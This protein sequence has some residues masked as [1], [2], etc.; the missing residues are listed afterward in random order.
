MSTR[1][2]AAREDDHVRDRTKHRKSRQSKTVLRASHPQ[3]ANQSIQSSLEEISRLREVT[4]HLCREGSSSER[5]EELRWKINQLEKDKLE[6]TSKYN[7]EVSGYEAQLARLRALLERGEANRQTLEY[8]VAVVRRDA[9]VQKSSSEDRIADLH[10]HNQQLKTLSAE[11]SQRV[12]DLERALEITR[13]AREEDQQGLQAELHERDRLLLSSNAENDLLQAE[14]RR[15]EALLQEQNDTLKELKDKM[16]RVQKGRERD[17]EELRV[18]TSELKLSADREERMRTEVESAMQR[19]KALEE[20][21]ESERAAHLESKFNSEIIQLRL[22]DLEAAL[23]VEKNSQAEAVSNLELLRQ[24]F[25]EVEKAYTRERDR[26]KDTHHKLQQLEKEYLSTKTELIGQLDKEKAAAAELIGQLEQE[27][28][29]SVKLSLRLQEEERVQTENQHTLSLLQKKLVWVEEAHEGLLK[30]MEQL[31][32]HYHHLGAPQINNTGEGDKHSSS[33]MMDILRRTLQHYHTELKDLLKV[34]DTLKKESKEKEE[35]ITEQRRHIQECEGQCVCLGE[36]VKRLRVSVTEAAAAAD[37]AQTELRNV[38]QRWEEER[39]RHTHTRA[40]IHTLTQ[41]HERDQQEKLA[42]LHSLYQQLVAGCVLVAPPQSML[43]SFSWVELSTVLQEHVDALASDLSSAN[44]KISGLESVCEGKAAAL[45]SVCEQLKQREESWIRQREELDTHHTQLTNELQTRVQNLRRTLDQ[46][47]ESIRV[48]ERGRS[49]LEQELTRLQ[50]LLSVCRRDDASLLAAC[51][52]L[53]GCVCELYGRV[54]V[55]ARQKTLLWGRVCDGAALERE[56]GSLLHALSEPEVKGQA[57]VRGGVWA[58]RRCVIA[59]L[60]ALRLQALQRN[61]RR[62]FRVS[63]RSGESPGV[64]VREVRLREGSPRTEREEEEEERSVRVMKM[65]RSSELAVLIHSCMQ[66]VQQELDK[67]ELS[68]AVLNA[69]QNSFSKLLERLLSETDPGCWGRW[70]NV[71]ML[72]R[73]LGH[74]LQRLRTAHHI[75]ARRYTSKCMVSSLQQHFLV[76]TQRLHSAEVERRELRLELSRLKRSTAHSRNKP[77]DNTH[78][79]CVPVNQFQSVCAELSSALQ[80][81]QEVQALLHQQ[82]T[83]LQELGLTMELHT[84]DQLEKDRTLAQAVQ[85]LSEAKAELKR[86]EQSLRLLGKR[87]S[88]SQQEKQQLQQSISSAEN[89]LR[90]A[91]KNKDSL[92]SYVKSVESSLKELKDR[93]ILSRSSTS[94]EDFT[95]H[96]P[97]TLLDV[98]EPK[99][100]TGG[101]EIAACQTLVRS[102]LEVY[103]LACSKMASLEREISSYQSHITALKAELQDACLRESQI[104]V[105]VMGADEPALPLFEVEVDSGTP[106]LSDAGVTLKDIPGNLRPLQS[107]PLKKS[108]AVKKGSK[109][110]KTLKG[111]SKP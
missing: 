69:A 54:G 96:L 16:D 87:L 47:E 70:G 90:M 98:A 89:A 93:I 20:N 17:A 21:V 52:L 97:K 94:R 68:S 22:R 74:G 101:P 8:E 32:Q 78:T 2:A 91:A 107:V 66:G 58:F 99:W 10:K 60:A 63:S 56:V 71:G 19:M 48:L 37:R 39:E 83:Q 67:T 7:Q 51:A 85:S 109:N 65:L 26:A 103:Q 110:T 29:E 105:P 104:Y 30:E 24:Q 72:A 42:F 41:E 64:C 34:V 14:K 28:A 11:L 3:P 55:L 45:A 25:G 1:P 100:N 6:L 36:E 49:D 62:L 43:G 4:G 75:P 79:T 5:E 44:Q 111:A 73:Q 9:A 81:E 13:Q 27:R 50:D 38:T 40:Q 12:S 86:K 95:L 15:L 18:K 35:I 76:F 33:A 31:L 102:F 23:C 80:R 106:P 84:G 77:K 53:A 57:E 61:S 88:Q 59:V 92:A 82:A 46:A 108:K